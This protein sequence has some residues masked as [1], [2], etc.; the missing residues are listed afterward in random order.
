MPQS[1]SVRYPRIEFKSYTTP[2]Y[3]RGNAFLTHFVSSLNFLFPEGEDFFVES[4][5]LFQGQVRDPQLQSEIKN[6]CGQELQHKCQTLNF[7]KLLER[8]GYQTEGL[9]KNVKWVLNQIRRFYTPG[10]KLSATATLEHFS[11]TLGHCALESRFLDGTE[12]DMRKLLV[13]H[14]IEEMEHKHVTFD[15]LETT[16]S[17]GLLLRYY[18]ILS[19]SFLIFMLVSLGMMNLI[20]QDLRSNQLSLKQLGRHFIQFVKDQKFRKF[21]LTSLFSIAK[22]FR[23]GF[24]PNQI[25]DQH[26]L[27]LYSSELQQFS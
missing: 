5:R 20:G 3:L 8:Q 9:A 10:M 25:D 2:Y 18:C 17:K 11:A 21:V 14:A 23:P 16:E 1:F 13:W 24:H 7:V 22:Y 4:I 26:L 6:F 12:P 27:D 19:A 15:V